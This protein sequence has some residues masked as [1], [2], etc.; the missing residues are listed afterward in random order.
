MT[1]RWRVGVLLGGWLAEGFAGRGATVTRRTVPVSVSGGVRSEI[2]EAGVAGDGVAP[3]QDVL[4]G[5]GI[6]VGAG[7]RVS[8]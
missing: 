3:G 6:G 7:E 5:R 1:A 2:V 8:S 4:G